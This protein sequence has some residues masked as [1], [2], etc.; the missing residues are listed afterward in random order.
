MQQNQNLELFVWGKGYNNESFDPFCLSV[1]TYLT[2]LNVPFVLNNENNPQLSPTGTF[3]FLRDGSTIICGTLNIFNY[4]KKK[5]HDLDHHLSSKQAAESLAYSTLIEENLHLALLYNWFLETDNYLKN[6][7]PWFS[8]NYPFVLRYQMPS[9]LQKNAT[10]RLSGM[11]FVDVSGK[12]TPEVYVEAKN[13]YENF[14]KKLG[15]NEYIFGS[16]PSSLD[17][18]LYSHL[19]IHSYPSLATPTLFSILTFNFPNLINYVEKIKTIYFENN[20]KENLVTYSPITKNFFLRLLENPKL[21]I[22]ETFFSNKYTN[23]NDQKNVA[24]ME[25]VK[26]ARLR[27]AFVLGSLGFFVGY[28]LRNDCFSAPI[29]E[30]ENDDEYDD[31]Y[32]EEC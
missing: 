31:Y 14:T 16:K 1:I 27:L 18:I 6:T 10:V 26:A 25:L 28:V 23:T 30:E 7:R 8:R 24:E 20:W 22:T 5:G 21:T 11:R 9:R 3:P 4:L 2:F 32:E 19:A 17:A 12:K 15:N 13:I 29:E